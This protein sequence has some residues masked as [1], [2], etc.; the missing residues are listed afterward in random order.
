MNQ[1]MIPTIIPG[2]R[3]RTITQDQLMRQVIY[4][5][6]V[7]SAQINFSGLSFAVWNARSINKKAAMICVIIISNRL[8]IF[9]ITESWLHSETNNVAIVELLNT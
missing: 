4:S 9:S 2:N 6:T 1:S 3:P 7:E 5:S 8:D